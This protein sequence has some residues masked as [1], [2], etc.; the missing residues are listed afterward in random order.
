MDFKNNW[1]PNSIELPFPI[2]ITLSDVKNL[3]FSFNTFKMQ[4]TVESTNNWLSLMKLLGAYL[5]AKFS[6]VTCVWRQ[7]SA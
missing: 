5:G 2:F 4:G 3:F 7:I 1:Q 6:H